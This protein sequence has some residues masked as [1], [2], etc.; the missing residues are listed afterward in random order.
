MLS[1]TEILEQL[2]LHRVFA[3][4]DEQELIDLVSISSTIDLETG[5]KVVSKDHP[6]GMLFLV[7][8]GRLSLRMQMRE[9]REFHAG[10]LFGEIGLFADHRRSGAVI[11][12]LPSQLI[13]IDADKLFDDTYIKPKTALTITRALTRKI[14]DYLR[15]REQLT[16]RSLI[17]EGENEFVEFKSSLR[18]NMHIGKKDPRIQLA[19]IKSIAAFLN[20]KGGTLLVG[21]DDAG[22]PLGLVNE[23]FKNHDKLLLTLNN[24]C[25]DHIG[26]LHLDHIEAHIVDVEGVEILR[27]D[28]EPG[29]EPAYVSH[30]H[31][32]HFFVRTG[33]S[34]TDLSLRNVYGYIRKRFYE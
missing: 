30:G 34:T 5:D 25:K 2:R 31:E 19:V 14:T 23:G 11:A 3:R 12:E 18:Y 21:I 22:V 8:S 16:T 24:L 9:I 27:I 17:S 32:E 15:R 7:V 1:D 26:Q 33:P 20:S 29:E 6:S 10:E 4:L 13:Q 28:V